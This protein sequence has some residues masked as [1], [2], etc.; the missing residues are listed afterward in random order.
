MKLIASGLLGNSTIAAGSPFATNYCKSGASATGSA[1]QI[2]DGVYFI[3][4]NFV[5]VNR[6]INS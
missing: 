4:G 1:F 3:R 6:N 5:N 2:Q